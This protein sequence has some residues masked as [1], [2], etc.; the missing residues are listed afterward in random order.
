MNGI[1]VDL[2]GHAGNRE[3]SEGSSHQLCCLLCGGPALGYRTGSGGWTQSK[4]DV[5][6]VQCG[7]RIAGT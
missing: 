5:D 2:W 1:G 4:G 7:W 6:R 3:A